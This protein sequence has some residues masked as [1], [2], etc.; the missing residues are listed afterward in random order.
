MWYTETNAFLK[1]YHIQLR[2]FSYKEV[3]SEVF[4]IFNFSVYR[5]CFLACIKQK[6][7]KRNIIVPKELCLPP[8]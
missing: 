1:E 6:L 5:P 8:H 7:N 4:H 3:K 2:P